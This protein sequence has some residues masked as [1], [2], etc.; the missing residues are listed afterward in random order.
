M[1]SIATIAKYGG[2]LL[3]LPG[4]KFG[5]DLHK[6][7]LPLAYVKRDT[8]EYS[9]DRTRWQPALLLTLCW[10]YKLIDVSAYKPNSRFQRAI[11]RLWKAKINVDVEPFAEKKN[12]RKE[13]LAFCK[14]YKIQI[15]P[16]VWNKPAGMYTSINDFF[17]RTYK[18]AKVID[19]LSNHFV[20]GSPVD[21]KL[22]LFDSIEHMQTIYIKSRHFT[23]AKMELPSWETYKGSVAVCRL[24]P[25]DYHN[26]HMPVTG[27]IVNI[28]NKPTP[29]PH[30]MS[31]PVTRSVMVSEDITPLTYNRIEHVIID[32][33]FGLVA[34][35]VVGATGVGTIIF[36]DF[37]KP[38]AFVDRGNLVGRFE[39]G[40]S[41][42]VL[43][44][45]H[46]VAWDSD[47]TSL[48]KYNRDNTCEVALT[49]GE[50]IGVGGQIGV[51]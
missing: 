7:L 28:Y 26:F 32:T 14:R 35:C 31:H 2:I 25:S 16:W 18:E 34:M 37:F 46:R 29:N 49:Y 15:D 27:K 17:T 4:V 5:R 45:E 11:I 43:I 23:L 41:T 20:I 38:G 42:I 24:A 1:K 47:I 51:L 8:K 50:Q 10:K 9:Q 6:E 44:T 48:H 22:L 19:D 33:A 39:K 3:L 40:G 30:N 36:E 21:C 13:V 12:A